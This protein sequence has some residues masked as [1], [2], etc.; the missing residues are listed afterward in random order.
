MSCESEVELVNYKKNHG[1]MRNVWL[2]DL[3][4]NT[5]SRS[6]YEFHQNSDSHSIVSAICYIGNEILKELRKNKS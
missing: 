4:A 2:C 5:S 3:C 1:P 6:L